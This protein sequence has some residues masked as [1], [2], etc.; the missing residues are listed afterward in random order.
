M[1]KIK[2]SSF[3]GNW[4]PSSEKD[5]HL[6]LKKWDHELGNFERNIISGIV[7]HA[8][9]YF[10]GIYAYD[11]MRRISREIETIVLIG[12][13]LPQG[14]PILTYGEDF[15]ETPCGLIEVNRDFIDSIG[16]SCELAVDNGPDNTIEVQ[17]PVIK[18]LFSDVKIVPLRVPSGEKSLEI[19]E[20]L[21]G[22]IFQSNGRT[23]VIGSTDLTH[24][25]P[26]Y[27]F[28]PN[29]SL[30]EPVKWVESSDRK[31][32]DAMVEIKPLN[33]LKLADK[34]RS[35]CSAGAAVCAAQ[36]ASLSGVERG[37]LL[38]YETSLSRHSGESFV[39]YGAV[40]YEI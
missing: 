32:L 19:L 35:A 13:H 9:W 5:V 12:G 39:A 1:K 11:V 36:F 40:V 27:N 28:L 29:P 34:D 2:K 10:S 26:S 25:G 3:T 21:T 18:S 17:L 15:L 4:Y 6:Q 22:Y 37:Q 8:G 30:E 16:T 23:A 14:Y 24:Y 20:E 38:S 31:I 33:I 7:P